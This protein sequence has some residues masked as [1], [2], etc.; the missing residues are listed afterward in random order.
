[1]S[2]VNL[3]LLSDVYQAWDADKSSAMLQNLKKQTPMVAANYPTFT[4]QQIITEGELA[5]EAV[6]NIVNTIIN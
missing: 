1:M 5:H 6:L 3:L 4:R 2:T